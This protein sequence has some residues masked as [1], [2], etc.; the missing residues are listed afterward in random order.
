MSVPSVYRL[1]SLIREFG[2]W[3]LNLDRNKMLSFDRKQASRSFTARGAASW[4]SAADVC[5]DLATGMSRS[6]GKNTGSLPHG[7][8][9]QVPHLWLPGVR[10]HLRCWRTIWSGPVFL[11]SGCKSGSYDIREIFVNVIGRVGYLES[12][13]S[14][15]SSHL[16]QNFQDPHGLPCSFLFTLIYSKVGHGYCRG[17]SQKNIS[18]MCTIYRCAD[19]WKRNMK[20]ET[21]VRTFPPESWE[22]MNPG[23]LPAFREHTRQRKCWPFF[24]S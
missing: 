7:P 24:N 10:I 1:F 8:W 2:V 19:I 14:V 22:A 16:G 12:V 11:V 9:W 4:G 15:E 5:S 21:G 13:S 23:H 6:S 3:C 18:V 17:R 20:S